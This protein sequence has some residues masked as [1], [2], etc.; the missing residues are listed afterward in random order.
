MGCSAAAANPLGCASTSSSTMAGAPLGCQQQGNLQ[1]GGTGPGEDNWTGVFCEPAL[2]CTAVPAPPGQPQS[3]TL[4][5]PT[6]RPPLAPAPPFSGNQLSPPPA[7]AFP[8]SPVQS[9]P[10][11]P[12]FGIEDTWYGQ[13][14][15]TPTSGK[16]CPTI[17]SPEV[18]AVLGAMENDLKA[19]LPDVR[20]VTVTATAVTQRVSVQS[21]NEYCCVATS[22]VWLT[23]YHPVSLPCAS[24]QVMHT[25]VM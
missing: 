11:P 14:V 8:P 19:F 4:S 6:S 17:M 7:K 23:S 1:P 15:V 9:S 12:G 18:T 20:S 10:Q 13:V 24:S 5:P 2:V 25:P 22:L 16:A 21:T 3:E